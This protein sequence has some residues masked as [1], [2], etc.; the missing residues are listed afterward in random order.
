[1]NQFD[2]DSA[3]SDIYL[4]KRTNF[5]FVITDPINYCNLDKLKSP[6]HLTMKR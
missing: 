4:P 1:M 2:Q 3:G 5:G 6:A